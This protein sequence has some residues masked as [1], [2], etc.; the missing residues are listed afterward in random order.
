MAAAALAG[1]SGGDSARS[2]D[3]PPST[4]PSA[5]SG[6]SPSGSRSGSASG[7]SVGSPRP[8]ASPR[9]RLLR[10][11]KAPA[12]TPAA[13]KAFARFVVARW[14]FALVT[15]DA[16]AITGLG[17]KGHACEGCNELAAEL[18]KRR[19]QRWYVAFP[20]AKVRTVTLAPPPGA[21]HV[22][23]AHVRADIPASRSVFKNGT[24]RNENPAHAGATFDVGM[25][26][27][28]QKYTLLAFR[29]R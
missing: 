22:S 28:H 20:G 29:L 14:G 11:P 17:P 23:I 16:L 12:D 26:Y 13:R 9:P 10:A 8:G 4:K 27:V 2:S 25:S 15:D 3:A 21:P 19:T 5:S 1:C 6:P 24:F 7:S 18:S